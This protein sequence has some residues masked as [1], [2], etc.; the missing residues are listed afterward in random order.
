MSFEIFLRRLNACLPAVLVASAAACMAGPA[1]AADAHKSAAKPRKLLLTRDELRACMA[2]KNHLHDEG[3]A[4]VQMQSKL[5][6]EKDEIVQNGNELKERLAA[7]DRTNKEVVQKYVDDSNAREKRIDAFEA[8]GRTY[9]ERVQALE[10]AR[11]AYHRDCE[12]KR[13]DLDD[14]AAI[15]KGK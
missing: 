11:A 15:R 8:S 3:E 1:L 4:L 6:T 2:A 10:N 13:F 9:N 14:E 7:L 5:A 12:N